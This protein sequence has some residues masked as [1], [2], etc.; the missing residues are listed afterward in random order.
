MARS[1]EHARSHPDLLGM[2]EVRKPGTSRPLPAHY[3]PFLHSSLPG[4]LRG[5]ESLCG[6]ATVFGS[7]S[8]TLGY[9]PI[10]NGLDFALNFQRLMFPVSF[11]GF[12]QLP[13]GYRALN[14]NAPQRL[15]L[16]SSKMKSPETTRRNF[17]AARF[18]GFHLSIVSH[19]F[20]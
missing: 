9:Y 7:G 14:P 17:H 15:R 6:A 19:P 12:W 1:S 11:K 13:S 4:F 16:I 3:L 10:R 5:L 8:A 18:W 2:Q 20:Q